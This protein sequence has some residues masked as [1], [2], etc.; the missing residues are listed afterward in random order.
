MFLKR[1]PKLGQKVEHILQLSDDQEYI[2]EDFS[3]INIDS[4][5]MRN[6]NSSSVDDCKSNPRKSLH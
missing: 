5:L 3:S 1:F 2:L 6:L 4:T